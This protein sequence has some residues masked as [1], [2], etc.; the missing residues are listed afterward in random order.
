VDDLEH[1]ALVQ[2][3]VDPV[4]EDGIVAA[5]VGTVVS[6]L[7]ALLL[8][9]QYAWLAD[10]SQGWWLWVALTATGAGVL[11]SAYA[12]Y[13]KRQRLAPAPKQQSIEKQSSVEQ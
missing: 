8:W 12:R 13:R 7:A 4:D 9:W 6:A 3:P 1:H 11:F 5:F 2:A 10:R